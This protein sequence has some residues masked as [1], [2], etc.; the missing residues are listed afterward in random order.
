MRQQHVVFSSRITEVL[1]VIDNRLRTI[2]GPQGGAALHSGAK[3]QQGGGSQE[4]AAIQE[5]DLICEVSISTGSRTLS[6]SVDCVSRE[7]GFQ[8]RNETVA[9]LP[10]IRTVFQQGGPIRAP[11]IEGLL[12][13]VFRPWSL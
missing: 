4:F 12:H 8:M 9:E 6:H 10:S 2:V 1:V 5:G 7:D 3:G 13:F 11:E